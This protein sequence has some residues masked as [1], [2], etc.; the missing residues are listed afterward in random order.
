MTATNWLL[1]PIAAAPE[2]IATWP[3]LVEAEAIRQQGLALTRELLNSGASWAAVHAQVEA[4]LDTA[5]TPALD[6]AAPPELG[7][8]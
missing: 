8:G 7:G 1:A 3:P 2:D 6:S 4:Y 5:P